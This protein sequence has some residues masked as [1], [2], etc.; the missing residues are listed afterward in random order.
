MN[1]FTTKDGAI[2]FYKECDPRNGQ[3]SATASERPVAAVLNSRAH[4][5]LSE[6]AQLVASRPAFDTAV[7]HAMVCPVAVSRC[8]SA[9]SK[10]LPALTRNPVYL[11][12]IEP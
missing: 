10:S 3:R 6:P 4:E 11:Q 5:K 8:A 7:L 9:D 2:I 1:T 12:P